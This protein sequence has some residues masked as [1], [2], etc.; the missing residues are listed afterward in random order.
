MC[1]HNYTDGGEH[2]TKQIWGILVGGL[3]WPLYVRPVSSGPYL[4]GAFDCGLGCTDKE[5]FPLFGIA[6]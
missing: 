3:G 1:M 4:V 5:I 2:I 6:Q